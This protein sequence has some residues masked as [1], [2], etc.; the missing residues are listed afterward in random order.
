MLTIVRPG[1]AIPP[2]A[3]DEETM[4]VDDFR[5]WL[6]SGRAV[7]HIARYREARMLVHRL[8]TVG[9]PLPLALALRALA[10]GAIHVE[11]ARGHRRRISTGQILSW[12]GRFASEPF[13][14]GGVLQR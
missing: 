10:R 12:A 9:R 14:V 11:D 4:A 6:A 7:W 3:S 8:E 5:A 2:A 1:L 13:R